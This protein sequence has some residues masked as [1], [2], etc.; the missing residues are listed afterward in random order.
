LRILLVR[1]TFVRADHA[2]LVARYARK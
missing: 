1:D 2:I